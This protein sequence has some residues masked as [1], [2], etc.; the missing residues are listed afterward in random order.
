ME[1]RDILTRPAPPPDLVLRYGPDRDHVA[2]LRLPAVP[3]TSQTAAPLVV[4]LH[5][6]FWRAAYD[7]A[8]TGPRGPA[9][10]ADRLDGL[11]PECRRPKAGSIPAACCWPGTLRAG[12][13]PCG[14]Q[15][16]IVS[17]PAPRGQRPRAR[18]H[19]CTWASW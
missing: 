1:P 6:G 5:G 17:R 19:P 14:R 3:E 13:W 8:P 10:A 12:T 9:R 2:D 18:P 15:A 4:F 11:R 16:G 7:P